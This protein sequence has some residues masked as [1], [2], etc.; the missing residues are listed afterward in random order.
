MG[1]SNLL[2]LVSQHRQRICDEIFLDKEINAVSH[3]SSQVR[4]RIILNLQK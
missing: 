1:F 3:H 4:S 2:H